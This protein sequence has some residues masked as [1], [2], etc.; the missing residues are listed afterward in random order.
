MNIYAIV[1]TFNGIKWVKT[2]FESLINSS[3][4]PNILVVDNGSTD[5]TLNIIRKEYPLV[6]V[7]ETG[8]NL[9]FAKANN[10][11]IKY[12]LDKGTEYVFLLN[13]DA[14]VKSNTI[15]ELIDLFPSL[16]N[17]GILSP[18]HL[19]GTSAYLEPSFA[20]F[21]REHCSYE[22]ISDL[23]FNNLKNYYEIKFVNAAA[24]LISRRCIETV[25]GF[26]TNI[27]FHYGEDIN[28]SQRLIFHGFKSYITTKT[29]ICHNTDG[30]TG[31]TKNFI[32]QQSDIW[33]KVVHS[34]ILNDEIMQSYKKNIIKKYL[35][36]IV[37]LK[38]LEILN[39]YADIKLYRKIKK[40][41]ELN[42]IGKLVWL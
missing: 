36:S 27:F 31:F 19:N 25:G 38:L 41:R 35:K 5:G 8:Q 12:A 42:K 2:C 14:Q 37:R 32:H 13:Q 34:N 29:T 30:R 28:Y 21:I 39:I 22:I 6:E 33:N 23:Y 17:A 1:V 15:K 9:G 7:I 18:I 20:N 16:P 11:G 24:W 3:V 26:D 4:V 10:I 40:S